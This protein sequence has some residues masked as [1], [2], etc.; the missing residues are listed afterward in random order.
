MTNLTENLGTKRSSG[1]LV[2][3]LVVRLLV[4]YIGS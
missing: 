3:A 2:I 1:G 4:G